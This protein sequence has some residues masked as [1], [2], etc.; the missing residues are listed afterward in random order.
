MTIYVTSCKRCVTLVTA[1]LLVAFSSM[2]P[3]SGTDKPEATVAPAAKT[4]DF[5]IPANKAARLTVIL[6]S[7]QKISARLLER[8]KLVRRIDRDKLALVRP[9]G[10]MQFGSGQVDIPAADSE[11][12]FRIYVE[13]DG[14]KERLQAYPYPSNLAASF[15]VGTMVHGVVSWELDPR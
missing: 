5:T 7:E 15:A 6:W 11:R 8:E 14:R 4:F 3:A 13:E 1:A 2:Y 12:T 9:L 10:K